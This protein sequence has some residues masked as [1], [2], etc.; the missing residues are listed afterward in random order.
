MLPTTT[1]RNDR[2]PHVLPVSSSSPFFSKEAEEE[3]TRGRD[4]RSGTDAN[5]F[6][7]GDSP[8]SMLPD[9][10]QNQS[11]SSLTPPAA[12]KT[13]TTM[14]SNRDFAKSNLSEYNLLDL[15]G[16]GSFGK[17]YKARKKFTG[18]TSAIKFI[19]KKGKT[20]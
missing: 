10:R 3:G 13:A 17:V 14:Q 7:G 11:P 5:G 12:I 1:E 6:F 19:A 16:E 9:G 15:V 4:S 20:E 2:R 8:S 18:E